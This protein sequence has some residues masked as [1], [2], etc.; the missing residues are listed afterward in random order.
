MFFLI[1]AFV[2]LADMRRMR[3][4]AIWRLVVPIIW[5]F[6]FWKQF[7]MSFWGSWWRSFW[8]LSFTLCAARRP[9][10]SF[11]LL[12]MNLR[13]YV[14]PG[15]HLFCSMACLALRWVPH[16]HIP[17]S[18]SFHPHPPAISPCLPTHNPFPPPPPPRPTSH[19]SPIPQNDHQK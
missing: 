18:T 19:P 9:G 7:R 14:R 1:S 3:A 12:Y 4:W 17:P 8:M 16:L 15:L 11:L 10:S 13:R 6:G 5:R 2:P